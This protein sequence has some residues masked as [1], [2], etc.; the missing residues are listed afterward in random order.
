MPKETQTPL[1]CQTLIVKLD[2][3]LSYTLGFNRKCFATTT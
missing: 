1:F 2:L 3:P